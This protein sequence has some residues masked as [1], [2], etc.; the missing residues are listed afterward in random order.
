MYRLRPFE[1]K[2]WDAVRRLHE[3]AGNTF[4][5]P[6]RMEEAVVAVDER[7]GEVVGVQGT[8]VTREGYV[9]IDHSWMT[10]RARWRVFEEMHEEIRAELDRKKVQDWHVFV[11]P[12]KTGGHSGFAKRLMKRLGWIPAAW[13]CYSRKVK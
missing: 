8:R 6:R 3:A 4:E 7:T 11:E 12:A 1:H 2:D 5:V 13:R 9:W 10:P